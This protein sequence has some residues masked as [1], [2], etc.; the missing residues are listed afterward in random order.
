MMAND[1]ASATRDVEKVLSEEVYVSE[2]FVADGVF[3][4]F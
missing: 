2:L 3:V 1:N 4:F